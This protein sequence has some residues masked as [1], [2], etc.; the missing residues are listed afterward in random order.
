MK[1]KLS[2]RV[3][4]VILCL[5]LLMAY[6]PMAAYAAENADNRVADPSTMDGWKELFLSDPLNTE[7]AGGVWTDKSVFTDASAFAGTG[8]TR[9]GDDSFLVALSAMA[10]NMSVTGVTNVPTDTMMILDLSSSMYNGYSRNPATVRSMLTAVNNSIEKLHNLNEHNRVGVVIYY[11]GQ[12]RNQS[13]SSNSMVLLPLDRYSGTSTYLKANVSGGRLISVAVNSGVKNSAGKTVAQTTR[14]VTDVAGTYAQLG[15]LDAMNQLLAADTTVPASA[16]YQSEVTRVPVM[17]FMSDGEPTAATHQY[18]KKVNAGMGNNT[19][20]IRN[21]NETDFVTQLTAAYAKEMVDVHYVET[22]PLFYTLSL[23]TSVSLAVMEPAD[24]T[25]ATIDGYWNKLLANGS[26]KITVYN[27]PNGWGNPTVKKTYTVSTTT[28]DGT[29]FPASKSQRNYVDKAFTA[30]N[31]SNLTDAFDNIFN[32]I[33]LVSKY[34]PT[35]ISGNADLSGYISF[36]DK[37][38]QY[39]NVT[40]IKGVLIDDI[41]YSGVDLAKNFVAGGGELGTYDKPTPLGDEMVWAVQA[42]LGLESADAARTLIGLAHEHGQLRYTSNTD[43]SNYIGWYANA[44]GQFLGFWHEDI[45][46]MPAPTGDP[47]T[48]PAYIIKSYGY[49]GAVDESQGVAASDLMYATVQVRQSIATGEQTVVFAVPAALIPIVSY[50]VTLGKNGELTELTATGAEHPIR[51]VYEVALDDHINAFN[52]K[53]TVS[54]DYLAAHTDENGRVSFYTNQY[55]VDL[56]TGYNKVNTYSYFN[57]SRQNDKY[58]YLEDAPVYTDTNGTLYTGD[59]HPSGTY[60]RSYTVYEKDGTTL[61]KKTAYRQL[62]DDALATAKQAADGSWYIG[63]G[64]VHV[65]LDGYTITKTENTTDTLPDAYIPFVDH[66]NHSVG[67]LG[68][69]FIIGATLGNNGKMILKP[70]TGIALSKKMAEGVAA[71]AGAFQFTITNTGDAGDNGA[72]PARML[73]ADG[74]QSETTVRF[75]AGKATVALHAGETIYIGGMTAGTT[76][77]V[78]EVPTLDYIPNVASV[79][80]TVKANE[81]TQ[82]SFINADRG[83]GGLTISKEVIHTLGNDYVIPAGKE[84]TVDVTLTGVGVASTTFNATHT[85]GSVTSVTTDAKGSFTVTLADHEQIEIVGLPAG[86]VATVTE[87]DP[88]TGFT[89]AYW[90]NDQLGDGVVTIPDG[91]TASVIVANSYE[92]E[93]VNPV[94]VVLNGTKIFTTAA[95]DWNGAQFQF[96]LQKWTDNGWSTIATAS[97]NEQNPSFN[98]NAALRAEKLAAPGTYY[99]QVL[100]TNGGNT[101]DGI[102]Y[103][104]TLHTFGITVTDKDMDGSLEIDKVASYH[105]GNAFD[106]NADGDWQIDVTF[107]NTYNATGTDLV[108]DVQKKLTNLSGSPLVSLSGFRFGLYDGTTL[109][110]SSELTDGV[111]EA[112]LILHYELKDEGTHTYTLK[113]IVP[114]NPIKNMTYDTTTAYT[115]VVEV[116]DN[117]DGTMSAAIVSI[118]GKTNYET[119][120]FTNVYDPE[121]AQLEIDFVN[122]KLTGRDLEAGEFAFELRQTNGTQKRTGANDAE[123]NVIFNDKLYFDKVGTYFF[124]LVETS[125]DGKGI[126]TDKTVYNVTVTVT[127]ENGQLIADHH[128]LNVAGDTVLFEN[129]YTAKEISYIIS[130]TKTLLGRV[131]LNEE[132]TFILAEAADAEGTI[133][134]NAMTLEAKNFTD[135]SFSF[136]KLTFTEAGT[137]YYVVWEKDSSG[138]DYG[139]VYDTTRYAVTITVTDD[140]EGQLVVSEVTMAVIGEDEVEN[141]TFTNKYIPAPTS[142]KIPGNKTLTGKVLGEGDFSFE[143]YASDEN[144]IEGDRL[145]TVE[146]GADGSFTFTQIDYETAGTRYYLVKETDGGKTIDGV[147]Y[148]DTVYRVAVEITDDL[149]GQLH[150]KINVYDDADIPRESVSFVNLYVITGDANVKLTGTKTLN[151]RDLTDGAFTFELYETDDSFAVSG[152]PIQTAVNTNGA[153]ELNLDYTAENVSNTYYYVVKERNAGQ[154][155]NGVTFSST[156]YYVTV[157]VGDNGT[158]GIVTE[159]SI[160][161]GTNAVNSLDFVNDYAPKE[162]TVELGGNKTMTGRDLRDGE[163]TFELYETNDSWFEISEAETVTNAIDGSFAFQPI[164]FTTTGTWYYL[165]RETNG[166]QV[167]D[168]VTYDDTIY[169]IIVDI[170]DNLEGQ[171][172][173]SLDICTSQGVPQDG[174]TFENS[175]TPPTTPDN[176][177]TA[178]TSLALW[179]AMLAVSCGGVIT[180]TACGKK[181]EDEE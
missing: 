128:I 19:V 37:V 114:E 68:Y 133:L 77:T 96:Q 47:A 48:D 148:D 11:G 154:T 117:G 173:A 126:V 172:Q 116:T 58:Y 105:T 81:L 113:E 60:Y 49:L 100:E 178:D 79:D 157:T 56:S 127:D 108:L 33:N 88:G 144:W 167:I 41:L 8:I 140:L 103:D 85:D 109:V 156:E 55:E 84:F 166:G 42:R 43:Y 27:S 98:F 74:T 14:T 95:H 17:I 164:T 45:T 158:G 101:I 175:Y 147:I 155:I 18:T 180:L 150:A 151:G 23:G 67:D 124:D 90:E 112:R 162:I 160:T 4:S 59:T 65:N 38:G 29:T 135:G 136:D 123:G 69:R 63:A 120:V 73:H 35:L 176:P 87:R 54:P 31:A 165:V 39:M 10:S 57:P 91:S 174:I 122:K 26:V 125:E 62:S 170:T 46:T 44:A 152:D 131:L 7:N 9:D 118:N 22:E 146:N 12:D 3:L 119:P 34:T 15:I 53:E 169:C 145:E 6:L 110:A 76:Y 70:E 181:E 51:L 168:N 50:E 52:L 138:A 115:V 92:P 64:N 99:Y 139:I 161:D 89:A 20:H 2:K 61:S 72:Y 24:N 32:Q 149:R 159:V 82:V 102:T 121:D 28:V 66:H 78:E 129:T 86:T 107:N 143:L 40:D 111:G 132:F 134:D 104:A 80:V 94:N 171:L 25:T 137:Y 71:P 36:V 153:F 21:A 141:I 163:F 106:I 30:E 83:T 16:D 97:A 177:Q 75:T 179:I 142:A 1:N 5:A 13:N 93:E 130:G